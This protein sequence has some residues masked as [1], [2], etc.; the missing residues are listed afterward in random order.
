MAYLREL[1]KRHP[2][3]R[4]F[5]NLTDRALRESS[6]PDEDILIYLSDMLIDFIS[7]DHLYRLKDGR[8]KDLRYWADMVRKVGEA[9]RSEKKCCYK[10]VGDYSLFILGMY[11]ESLTR[12][13]SALP[14]SYYVDTGR[15][16]YIAASELEPDWHST[17]IFR[18]L[19]EKYERCVL[20]LNWVREYTTDPFYQY[21]FRQFQIT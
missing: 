5:R 10:H 17:V 12:R 3:K 11:P 15:R 4:F 1:P 9:P 21:M 20:S 16:C 7:V 13:R 2:I 18:K 8:G 14:R 19:A 6:L